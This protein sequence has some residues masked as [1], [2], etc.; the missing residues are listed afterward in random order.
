MRSFGADVIVVAVEQTCGAAVAAEQ[1]SPAA[2]ALWIFREWSSHK[3]SSRAANDL[4]L[5]YWRFRSITLDVKGKDVKGEFCGARRCS[6]SA[7]SEY[8]LAHP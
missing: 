6:P 1:V 8:H 7:H 2:E 3:K 4:S 5:D